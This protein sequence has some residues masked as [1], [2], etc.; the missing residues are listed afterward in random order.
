MSSMGINF[1][2]ILSLTVALIKIDFVSSTGS[3]F[4]SI[5]DC[6]ENAKNEARQ[7]KIKDTLYSVSL[8]QEVRNSSSDVNLIIKHQNDNNS[9]SSFMVN[10][11][12]S[13]NPNL[14][15]RWMNFY[16][17]S[18]IQLIGEFER[19]QNDQYC[20][21]YFCKTR[22]SVRIKWRP[23]K[24]N[25][26]GV[27]YFY[28]DV[29]PVHYD[30][31]KSDP[32]P[33]IKRSLYIFNSPSEESIEE[34]NVLQRKKS[35]QHEEVEKRPDKE[36]NDYAKGDTEDHRKKD[37]RNYSTRTSYIVTFIISMIVSVNVIVCIVCSRSESRDHDSVDDQGQ[38]GGIPL[39]TTADDRNSAGERNDSQQQNPETLS[40]SGSY[41]I[42]NT[43][44][45]ETDD[46]PPSY[47]ELF[48]KC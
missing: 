36:L 43:N 6:S 42:K 3:S 12:A 25:I 15:I 16:D 32:Y 17:E 8:Q 34:S 40:T 5:C 24:A 39:E 47:S 29:Y 45:N 20:P 37:I 26:F 14:D 18:S 44:I 38:H 31:F 1:L 2:K 30:I 23:L 41:T 19:L 33:S 22:Q 13:R 27:I 28:I 10:L 35:E 46:L 21:H 4:V 7:E 48:G 11:A 9:H